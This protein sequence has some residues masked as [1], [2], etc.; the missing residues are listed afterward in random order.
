MGEN[1]FKSAV[2][3]NP[4]ANTNAATGVNAISIKMKEKNRPSDA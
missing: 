3:K 4:E 1:I 2:G